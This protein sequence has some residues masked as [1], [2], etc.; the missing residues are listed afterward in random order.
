MQIVKPARPYTITA[1]RSGNGGYVLDSSTEEL[2]WVDSQGFL[3]LAHIRPEGV[4]V[5]TIVDAIC[6]IYPSCLRSEINKGVDRFLS[7]LVREGLVRC[8]DQADNDGM[9]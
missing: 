8:Y 3:I 6:R 4:P 2:L 9:P 7:S 5:E 1:D